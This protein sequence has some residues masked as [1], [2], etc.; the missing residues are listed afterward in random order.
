MAATAVRTAFIGGLVMLPARGGDGLVLGSATAH[1]TTM[2]V[3]APESVEESMDE[4]ELR[5]KP[6][7]DSSTRNKLIKGAA[8]VG[9]VGAG[10]AFTLSQKAKAEDQKKREAEAYFREMMQAEVRAARGS[11]HVHAASR[12]HRP[13]DASA[14]TSR[15]RCLLSRW[16]NDLINFLPDDA[17][18][19]ATSIAAPPP[20]SSMPSVPP[21]APSPSASTAAEAAKKRKGFNLFAQKKSVVVPTVDELTAGETPSAEL[22]TTVAWA[23]RAPIDLALAAKIE[24]I[25]SDSLVEED[26]AELA[27]SIIETLN[28]VAT[29]SPAVG[30]EP[31]EMAKCVEQVGRAMLLQRVNT[32]V[33]SLDRSDEAFA[34]AAASLCFFVQNAE[35]VAM[36]LGVERLVGE[37][38][39]EGDVPRKRLE[40]LYVGCLTLAAP[41]L[42]AAMGMGGVDELGASSTLGLDTVEKLRPLLKIREGKSQRLIQEVMQKQMMG[43]MDGDDGDQGAMMARSVAMLEQLVESGSFQKS[44][45][46]SLKGMIS[47][48]F[49]MPVEEL[50]ERKDEL[51]DQLPTEGVKLFTLIE[52]LFGDASKA[53]GGAKSA[54]ASPDALADGFDEDDGD[55]T[56][57]V[58]EPSKTAAPP[59]TPTATTKVNVKVKTPV[60]E[61][62]SLA[63][64]AAPMP[65]APTPS[66]APPPSPAAPPPLSAPPL[67]PPSPPRSAPPPPPPTPSP[68][69]TNADGDTGL[70]ALDDLLG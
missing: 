11:V 19:A 62:S 7:P 25:E 55:F 18:A 3:D 67:P 36:C 26:D 33:D 54:G 56:V 49:G 60:S 68:P 15:P 28:E 14:P 42:L 31:A 50:L 70:D 59:I 41:E 48:S 34:D 8:V 44:D 38:L 24:G 29:Q 21:E 40:R 37:V 53:G 27:I 65:T 45:L 69:P 32:A 5:V 22:C 63:P 2:T 9:T 57:T 6:S 43:A 35:V 64:P 52:R 12:P 39:Y 46:D 10:M 58:R 61:Q 4:A 66:A 20:P 47:Q 30:I 13:P 16:Q 51:L 1:A 23:L 17:S